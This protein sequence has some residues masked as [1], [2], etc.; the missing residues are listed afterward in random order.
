MKPDQRKKLDEVVFLAINKD[1]GILE[2]FADNVL[3]EGMD[4]ADIAELGT[5]NMALIP[6]YWFSDPH[7]MR[8]SL[9]GKN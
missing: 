7:W 4:L 5:S 6:C 8:P 9:E 2:S 3:Q 1:L